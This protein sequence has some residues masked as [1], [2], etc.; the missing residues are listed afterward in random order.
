MVKGHHRRQCPSPSRHTPCL[1]LPHPST[2]SI[3]HFLSSF[4][5][6]TGVL[7]PTLHMRSSDC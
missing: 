7:N 5:A 2:D 1:S 6:Q 3:L 4:P